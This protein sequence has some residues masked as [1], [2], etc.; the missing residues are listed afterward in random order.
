[1]TENLRTRVLVVDDEQPVLKCTKEVLVRAGFDVDAVASGSAAVRL[2]DDKQ[3]DCVVSDIIMPGMS[4]ID[5]LRVIRSQDLD[6]PVVL[7][8]GAPTQQSAAQAVEHGAFKYVMKPLEPP[9]LTRLVAK[10]A[11]LGRMARFKRE[12]LE[13][14]GE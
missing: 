2:L 5:L 13:V 7:I 6:V 4:G 1:M 3:F 14:I 8:T 11:R 12:S 10:A 9:T